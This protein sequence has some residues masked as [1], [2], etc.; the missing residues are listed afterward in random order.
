M[1]KLIELQVRPPR[2][3]IE[4]YTLEQIDQLQREESATGRRTLTPAQVRQVVDQVGPAWL[5][6]Q[7]SA[8]TAKVLVPDLDC[9]REEDRTKIAGAVTRACAEAVDLVLMF[10]LHERIRSEFFRARRGL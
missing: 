8:A 7:S 3:A 1:G 10:V 4:R 2:L 5:S 6:W 9:L